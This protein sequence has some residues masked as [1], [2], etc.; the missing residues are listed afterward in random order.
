VLWE[1][2]TKGGNLSVCLSA[3]PQKNQER[4]S[5]TSFVPLREQSEGLCGVS[6][7]SVRQVGLG[8]WLKGKHNRAENELLFD[9]LERDHKLAVCMLSIENRQG[10]LS[11]VLSK[12]GRHG[13]VLY[14]SPAQAG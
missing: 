8:G 2:G 9:L 7:P 4:G 12:D 10:L 3:P 1:G 5:F 13:L 14:K 11:S 6:P